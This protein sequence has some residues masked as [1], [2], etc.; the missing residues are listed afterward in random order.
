M[1]LSHTIAAAG[2][3]YPKDFLPSPDVFYMLPGPH[4][5]GR[6]ARPGNSSSHLEGDTALGAYMSENP[7]GAE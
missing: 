6:N 1:L 5:M 7:G 3:V 2:F 4:S